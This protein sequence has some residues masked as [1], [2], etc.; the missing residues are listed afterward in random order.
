[1]AVVVSL[2]E[3]RGTKKRASLDKM[4]ALTARDMA[5]VNKVIVAR[6]DSPVALIPQLAGHI[7]AAGG[8]RLRPMLTLASAQLCDYAGDRH[9]WRWRPAS[10]SSTPPRLLHDDVVDESDLRRGLA[11][12]NALYGATRLRACWSATSCSARAFKLMVADGSAAK[13]CGIL[14]ERLGGDRRRRGR[15]SWSPPTIPTRPRKAYLRGHQRQDGGAVRRRLPDRR[16]ARRTAAHPRRR[17]WTLTGSRLRDRLS[18]GRRR[19]RL[20]GPPGGAGQGRS[21]T[22]SA[23]ARSPCRS[24]SP[25]AAA[26]RR[27]ANSGAAR[28]RRW[29]SARATLRK[30]SGCWRSTAR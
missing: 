26:R 16:G 21:A 14:S 11:T 13:C 28:W 7:V 22:T 4:S 3:G 12:A 6:M 10:N 1:M 5:R 2:N 23:K 20:L 29:T 27:S 9:I 17:P 19:A 8:K 18:T 30:R 25:I 15:C 24:C